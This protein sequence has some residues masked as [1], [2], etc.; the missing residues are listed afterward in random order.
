MPGDLHVRERIREEAVVTL[1]QDLKVCVVCGG[2]ES[3]TVRFRKHRRSCRACEIRG[4]VEYQKAHRSQV[5]QKNREWRAKNR[6]W[7]KNRDLLRTYGISLEQYR[8]M[9][10][11]QNHLCAICREPNKRYPH[12]AVDHDHKTKKIR[13]LLCTDCNFGIGKFRDSQAL[14]SAAIEYLVKAGASK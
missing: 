8:A 13:G 1:T 5:R 7:Q 11:E 14:L 6:D 12:L 4:R 9:E 3:E 2:T 10:R